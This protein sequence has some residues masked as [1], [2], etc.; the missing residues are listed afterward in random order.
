[1]AQ[2]DTT[3]KEE[4]E[5]LAS[6][7]NLNR[8]MYTLNPQGWVALVIIAILLVLAL[9]WAIFGTISQTATGRGILLT[10]DGLFTIRSTAS[11]LINQVV[12]RQ[13]QW[14]EKGDLIATVYDESLLNEISAT[15]LHINYLENSIAALE[16]LDKTPE[17]QK[18][19]YSNIVA[20][21]EKLLEQEQKQLSQLET[22]A[23]TV[24]DKE[25]FQKQL[26]QW[27]NQVAIM[28]R[29]MDRIQGDT[30]ANDATLSELKVQLQLAKNLLA[31]LKIAPPTFAIRATRTGRLIERYVTE[32]DYIVPGSRIML[33]TTPLQPGQPLVCHAYFDV[34]T[35]QK[36]YA[37]MSARLLPVNVDTQK[38]GYLK[39][40]VQQSS[41]FPV[42]DSAILAWLMEAALV[43]YMK[44]DQLV[45]TYS[46]IYTEINPTTF[47][48]Y[49]WSS[50]DGPPEYI[51]V[52]TV[53][54]VEIEL[55]AEP[56]IGVFFPSLN[57][58][59]PKEATLSNPNY[60]PKALTP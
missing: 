10:P 40:I 35:G 51:P 53:C 37:G 22:L 11:G 23:G 58:P 45:V 13:G 31:A 44:A 56:P 9:L 19:A 4:I 17:E 57:S 47:S 60:Y 20:E 41:R 55:A 8:I 42:S 36:I 46:H 2:D 7:E 21:M 5:R 15:E 26:L 50:P 54:I 39:G 33:G 34:A 12:A 1:M 32:G 3:Q 49:S 43:E 38:Y 25:Q 14:V 28:L 29:L 18:V 16:S 52:G 59:P 48:G 27:K 24:H 30:V 6:P